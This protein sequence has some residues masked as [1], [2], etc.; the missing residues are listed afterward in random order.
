MLSVN[1]YFDGKV[2]SIGFNA[3][4][5]PNA[6]L[7]SGSGERSWGSWSDGKLMLD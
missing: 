2:K 3:D 6:D 7:K 5:L 4:T 1:E